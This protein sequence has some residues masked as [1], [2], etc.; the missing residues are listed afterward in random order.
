VVLL[1][2]YAVAELLPPM[3]AGARRLGLVTLSQ[4]VRALVRAVEDPPSR[5]TVRMVDVA[6]IRRAR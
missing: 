2:A 4:M 3:R 6:A 1:P 5:G